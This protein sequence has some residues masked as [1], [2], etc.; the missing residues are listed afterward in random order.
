MLRQGLISQDS[1]LALRVC[2]GLSPSSLGRQLVEN[3]CTQRLLL[4]FR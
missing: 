1:E 3:P 2:E 4:L